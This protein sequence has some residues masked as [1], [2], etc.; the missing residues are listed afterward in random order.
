M[1]TKWQDIPRNPRPARADSDRKIMIMI[2]T[3]FIAGAAHV[4]TG[5]DHLAALAPLAADQPAKS[6]LAGAR[7]G[8]GHSTGVG[9][10]GILALVFRE[11]LP[12]GELSGWSERLVGVMLFVIGL[13]AIIKASR[14]KIHAH[15]HEH[16]ADTHIHVHVHAPGHAHGEDGTHR[17]DHA[18][19]GIGLLHG[20]AGSAHFFGVLPVL[21]LPSR[22]QAGL[23]LLTFSIGTVASMAAFSWFVGLAAGRSAGRS[24]QVYRGFINICGCAAMVVGAFWLLQAAH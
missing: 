23:Y 4:W 20:L 18:A 13:W 21:A 6:W 19:V 2:L 22:L 11:S 7:W 12:M 15:E 9:L 24:P 14:I 10:V 5:P 8:I 1:H 16:G 17:H 3:G